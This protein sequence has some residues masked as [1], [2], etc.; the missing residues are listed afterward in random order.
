MQEIKNIQWTLIKLSSDALLSQTKS[1]IQEER[2]ITTEIL[3]HLRE[4]DRRRLYL[5]MGF[6]SL[7]EFA[8]KH[9]GYSEGSAHRRITASRLLRDLPEI[10]TSLQSGKVTL[11]TLSLAQSFFKA[12]ERESGKT[13]DINEKR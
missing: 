13:Y 9:L 5:E 10:E 2:K 12:E 4:I 3:W 8:T 1:L 6:G 7:Y 11:T